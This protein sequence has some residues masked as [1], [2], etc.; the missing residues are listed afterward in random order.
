MVHEFAMGTGFT[1]LRVADAT[2]SEASR[3]ISDDEVRELADE[4]MRAAVRILDQHRPQLDEIAAT[5][6]A[7]EVIER[8]DIERIMRGVTS[9][10][11]ARGSSA[12]VELA[13]ATAMEPVRPNPHRS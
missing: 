11:A 6:L 2:V 5:L 8:Q 1:S 9:A 4:A 10:P 12:R 3:R 13:A 7:K